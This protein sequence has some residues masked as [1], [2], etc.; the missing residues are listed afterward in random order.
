MPNN[1]PA[2]RFHGKKLPRKPPRGLKEALAQNTGENAINKMS[3]KGPN[4]KFVKKTPAA[5]SAPAP[6]QVQQP[7]VEKPAPA[8]IQQPPPRSVSAQNGTTG[9]KMVNLEDIVN[10]KSQFKAPPSAEPKP[11]AEEQPQFKDKLDP[12][13][14]ASVQSADPNNP[15]TQAQPTAER[16]PPSST[17][18]MEAEGLLQIINY[19]KTDWE[20]KKFRQNVLTDEAFRMGKQINNDVTYKKRKEEELMEA[21]RNVLADYRKY[22]YESDGIEWSQTEVDLMKVPL[23]EGMEENGAHMPWYARLGLS[24]VGVEQ[25]R[26]R[27]IMKKDI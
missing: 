4:G 12:E 24:L 27:L 20:K 15:E 10:Q 14:L 8:P 13:K 23:A 1:Y 2:T 7:P 22:L 11:A 3:E 21:E 16:Q 5:Q 26:I 17:T 18:L 19:F 9:S 25:S 6:A